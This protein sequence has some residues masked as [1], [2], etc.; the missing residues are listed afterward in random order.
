MKKKSKKRA[1]RSFS[2]SPPSTDQK[3]LKMATTPTS[4]EHEVNEVLKQIIDS[5]KSLGDRLE[6]KIEQLLADI[7]CFH[8]K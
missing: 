3:K 4:K 2:N 6:N 5:I 1:E 7:D 8:T